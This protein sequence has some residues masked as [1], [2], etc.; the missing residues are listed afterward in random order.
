VTDQE[1]VT[2]T[3]E[4]KEEESP[5]GTRLQI[6]LKIASGEDKILT[7]NPTSKNA[8]IDQY[9]DDT[10]DWVGKEARIH[11]VK[12]LVSGKAKQVLYLTHPNFDL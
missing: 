11:I 8:L 1:L 5:Y 6:G 9:G 10:K 4:G 12:T 2:I 7:L 3:N